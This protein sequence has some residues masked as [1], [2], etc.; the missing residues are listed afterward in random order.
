MQPIMEVVRLP[1]L[2]LELSQKQSQPSPTNTFSVIF[3]AFAA[4]T[5]GCYYHTGLHGFKSN[6][7]KAA[8]YL[9]KAKE[10]NSEGNCCVLNKTELEN[11]K[12]YLDSYGS[13]PNNCPGNDMSV[14]SEI[15]ERKEIDTVST[16]TPQTE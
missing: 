4:Y 15:I 9:N 7:Q 1:S 6:A 14:P 12:R 10:F 3:V 13:P 2:I 8:K 11:I 16:L 5:L